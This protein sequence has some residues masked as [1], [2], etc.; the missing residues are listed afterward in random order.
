[1]S[2]YSAPE[3]NT[4]AFISGYHP[5]KIFSTDHTH[6][7]FGVGDVKKSGSNDFTGT[8]SFSNETTFSNTNPI[9]LET[10]S[11]STTLKFKESD[12]I[13]ATIDFSTDENSNGDLDVRANKIILKNS[14]GT[15]AVSL[16]SGVMTMTNGINA[17]KDTNTTSFLGRVAIGY[18]T[19]SDVATFAHH[20]FNNSSS[21]ALA[22]TNQGNTQINAHTGKD[23]FLRINNQNKMVVRDSGN[24]GIGT[25]TPSQKLHVDGN[26]LLRN[27]Q[28]DAEYFVGDTSWGLRV[29]NPT[30]STFFTDIVGHFNNGNS[31]G[32]RVYNVSPYILTSMI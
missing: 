29:E 16:S 11:G 32:F 13:T 6:S 22:H 3:R 17:G 21:Y 4:G 25:T 27:I 15:D 9:T 10:E 28:Y 24:V 14:A 2:A 12:T 23:I 18:A 20:D 31:R 7:G 19:D 1:M 5:K 30:S 26:I 8:N